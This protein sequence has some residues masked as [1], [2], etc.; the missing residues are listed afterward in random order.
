MPTRQRT[1]FRTPR[2]SCDPVTQ[3]NSNESHTNLKTTIKNL[4]AGPSHLQVTKH[5]PFWF[6]G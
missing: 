5:G 4:K 1:E 3:L 2:H 6:K